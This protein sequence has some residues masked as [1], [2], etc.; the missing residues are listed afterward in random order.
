VEAEIKRLAHAGERDFSTETVRNAEE[1]VAF[2]STRF[3]PPS[4]IQPG[5]WP[6]FSVSWNVQPSIEVEIFGASFEFY[7]FF[8][9]RTDIEEIMHRPGEPFPQRL[10]TLLS[11]NL[12]ALTL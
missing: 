10:D 11:S 7:R 5:Y 9:G 4:L 8:D 3:V 6:T 12:P 1:F 2:A